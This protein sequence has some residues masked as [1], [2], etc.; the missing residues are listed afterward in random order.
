MVVR[1]G[2]VLG[3]FLLG[4]G[5]DK[6]GSS[7]GS[8]GTAGQGGMSGSGG[9]SGSGGMSGTGGSSGTSGACTQGQT[10]ACWPSDA[11][12]NAR[13]MGVCRDG[14]QTCVISGEFGNWSICMGAVLPSQENCTNGQDDDCN[15]LTDCADPSCATDP[16]CRSACT[17]G[18]TRQ[19]YTGPANTQGIG[20]CRPGTQT[21]TGGQWPTDCPGEVLPGPENCMDSMDHNCNFLPGCLDVFSCL[22]APNC[23]PQCNPDP[24]CTCPTGS[25]SGDNAMCPAGTHGVATGGGPTSGGFV[26]CCPCRA[27][28]CGVDL[29]CCG[30][31]VCAGSS[32]CS[33]VSCRPL[34]ASCNGQVS[35]DCDDFPEDCDQA[36]CK[37]PQ[38]C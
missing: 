25:V 16:A 36:C 31:S 22:T 21:C 4:C 18:Q 14:M 5:P 17:D 26:E 3:V 24:G 13:G 28:D 35:F 7:G 20:T 27:Q 1:L 23:Q 15:G 29:E 38:G 12:P 2:L 32:A 9:Q 19:C 34:P 11:P 30:E 37:C 10:R 6:V 8:G 33:G